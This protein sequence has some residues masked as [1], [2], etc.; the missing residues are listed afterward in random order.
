MGVIDDSFD[1]AISTACPRLDDVVV[2]TVECAQHCIDYL[3][4]NKLGYARFILL[5]RLRQF[6][7]Q[8]IS[9]PEN[10]P[11]LFDLVKPK[12]PKFSNAFYSVLRDTLVAQNLKQANNVAYGKKRFRVVTVDGK[13]IDISGTM[14]GGGNHVAKG[15]MKL[16]TNQSDKVDDYTP[17]EVDKIERELS[18]RENNFRVA[19]DTVHEMEEELKN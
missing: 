16:G 12:N 5:D 11:R 6:N 19:S 4:K 7:L 10:V 1:V 17:E 3:R 13:L 15:L 8:P 14:S 2:D 18:E 9:T